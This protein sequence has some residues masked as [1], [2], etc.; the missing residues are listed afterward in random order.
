MYPM[1]VYKSVHALSDTHS[2]SNFYLVNNFYLFLNKIYKKK[3]IRN[4]YGCVRKNTPLEF[5]NKGYTRYK[6]YY[7]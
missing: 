7:E 4:D 5:S 1:K 6:F 2:R 3:Y